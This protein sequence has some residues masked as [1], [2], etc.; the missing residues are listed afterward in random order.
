MNT[1]IERLIDDVTDR[2]IE[3]AL[4]NL[5]GFTIDPFTG[6]P[7]SIDDGRYI[8]APS[9]A[10]EMALPVPAGA[11]L[12]LVIDRARVREWVETHWDALTKGKAGGWLDSET[13]RFV[14]DVSRGYNSFE[15]A[16]AVAIRGEQDAIF[17][18]AT[19][20]TIRIGA[21]VS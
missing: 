13:N 19:F 7:H 9:K 5:D 17:D 21:A 3:T 11:D 16:L 12:R 14:F 10:T 18:L 1:N 4:N 20:E 6:A 15:E 2:V 8:V